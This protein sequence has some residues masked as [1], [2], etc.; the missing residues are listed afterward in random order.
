[1]KTDVNADMCFFKRSTGNMSIED[2]PAHFSPSL[3]NQGFSLIELVVVILVLGVLATMALPAYDDLTTRA[4]ISRAKTEIGVVDK[5]IT[6]F[7]IDRN[8][9]PVQLSD[10]G[11]EA[12]ILDPWD[13][14]Y[15]YYNIGTGTG[16][17]G[18]QYTCYDLLEPNLNT[19]YDLYSLGKDGVTDH[20]IVNP[21]TDPPN[22]SSD[23]IVRA[24][25]G[26]IIEW[27]ADF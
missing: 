22:G 2:I 17:P 1:M 15:Q 9:L 18:P 20:D 3:N 10:V 11:A 8:S 24:R 6:A 14:A 25:N 7:I 16:S 19:D 12:N 27:G 21:G 23:D 13:H 4:T 26:S 5:A